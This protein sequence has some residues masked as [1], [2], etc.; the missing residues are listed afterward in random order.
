MPKSG[1]FPVCNLSA[2]TIDTIRNALEVMLAESKA[3]GAMVV[4]QSGYVIARRGTTRLMD[5]D[6]LATFATGA[7]TSFSMALK[8]DEM[9]VEFPK[10]QSD[11]IHFVQINPTTI[12]M[13]FI[14]RTAL[15]ESVRPRCQ[16]LVKKLKTAMQAKQA[17]GEAM[18]SLDFISSKLDEMFKDL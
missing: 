6:E 1:T 14:S 16:T 7:F 13:V 12:L 5:P 2:A 8:I 10:K 9:T 18:E 15:L 17:V 3:H 4:D 11:L